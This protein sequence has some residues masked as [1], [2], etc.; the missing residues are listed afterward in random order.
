[1][2]FNRFRKIT[3]LLFLTLPYLVFG[4]MDTI[5]I[6]EVVI[7]ES[8]IRSQMTGSTIQ[9]WATEKESNANLDLGNLLDQNGI[10]IKSYGANSLATSSIRGG[11]AGHTLVLWNGL[12]IQS[13][14]LGLLNLTLLPINSVENISLQKGGGSASWGSG[15]IG[16][17]VNLKNKAE[18]NN[19]FSFSANSI[20]GSFGQFNEQLKLA[21]GNNKFQ[22]V[23]KFFHQQAENDFHYPVAPGIPDRQQTNAAFHQQNVLH[24]VYLSLKKGHRLSAHFWRQQ[25]DKQLPPTITQNQSGAH[26]NDKAS[27]LILNWQHIHKHIVTNLKTAWFNEHLDYFN[28]L[29]GLESLSHFHTFLGEWT[30]QGSWNKQHRFLL[31]TSHSYTN[32]TADGYTNRPSENKTALFASYQFRKSRF[33][34]QATVRQEV[35]DQNFIPLTPAL[36]A[37]YQLFPSLNLAAKISRNYRLPTFN[38][39]YWQ[40]GGNPDLLA[41][42][43][44]SQEATL[45]WLLQ[46]GPFILKISHTAFNR[47]INNWIMWVPLDGQAFWSANNITKVWSRGL[48]ERFFLSFIRD[49]ITI[50]LQTG[51]DHIKSTNEVPLKVPAFAKGDQLLYT[52]RHLV[53]GSFSFNWKSIAVEYHHSYRGASK[54]VNELLEAYQTGRFQLEY[55]MANKKWAATL[56][57]SIINAW[58]A[59]YFVVERRPMAGRWFRIGLKTNW[60]KT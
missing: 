25:S 40:Q 34:F 23:T 12:P 39:R 51:Y 19:S 15:A 29:S 20:I 35:I 26:Q 32:V 10:F 30:A 57:G 5:A 31:G 16:G 13:P 59:N 50:Q 58:D 52:P 53:F 22:F 1:M 60:Q 38:D 21:V 18:F 9:N 24:D 47:K 54:G 28:D 44:W 56:F 36:S 45:L 41:E 43:G 27:R 55:Q 11:S 2:L 14:M 3:L 6:S 49:N 7:V 8:S 48:E 33:N 4:Q 42:S 46:K 17:V 37:N